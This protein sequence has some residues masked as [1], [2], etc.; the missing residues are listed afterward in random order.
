MN[1]RFFFLTLGFAAAAGVEMEVYDCVMAE[2]SEARLR[3]IR[4]VVTEM[5]EKQN[6]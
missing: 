2:K 5:A 4:R 1:T 6:I 3:T